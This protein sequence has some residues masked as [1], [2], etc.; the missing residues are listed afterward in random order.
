[1]GTNRHKKAICYYT[2]GHMFPLNSR[3]A[4]GS[5][6]PSVH[7]ISSNRESYNQ[8]QSGINFRLQDADAWKIAVTLRIVEPVA[9]EELVRHFPAKVV[10][11]DLDFPT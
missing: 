9:N 2:Y 6:S 10:N 1:M 5:H 4:Y 8:N 11:L 3:F 7:I